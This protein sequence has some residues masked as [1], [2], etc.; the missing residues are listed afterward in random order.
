M[1]KLGY[2]WYPKDWN[3][4]E[5]VFELTLQQRGLYRELIDLA[6]LND[7]KTIIKLPVWARKWAVEINDLE[8]ILKTLEGLG[9]IQIDFDGSNHLFIPSCEPR[10]N[11]VRGGSKGGKKS[12]PS[13]K[14]ISKPLPKP[15]ANQKKDKLKLKLNEI[16]DKVN[17]TH[18]SIL[19]KWLFYRKDSKKKINNEKTLQALV[20]RFNKTPLDE[21]EK[22][23]NYSIENGYQGLFWERANNTPAKKLDNKTIPSKADYAEAAKN[24]K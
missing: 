15:I 10:L 9:L 19:N 17:T 24:Q 11:L 16:K 13:V 7:N 3:N 1:A 14:P 18:S 22:V 5:S 23:V 20:D 2:T 21:V 8:S 12:K 4:S 6:M